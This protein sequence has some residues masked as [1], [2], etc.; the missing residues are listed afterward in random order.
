[1]GVA[2]TIILIILIMVIGWMIT[3]SILGITKKN[4]L[5]KKLGVISPVSDVVRES[6]ITRQSQPSTAM[7]VEE[8][9]GG[10]VVYSDSYSSTESGE[11]GSDM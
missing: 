10:D 5:Y 11:F 9:N 8:P 3:F 7:P 6:I 1:M 4:E 2:S